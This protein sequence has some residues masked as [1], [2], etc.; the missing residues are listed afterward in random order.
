MTEDTGKKEPKNKTNPET[1]K[2]PQKDELKS[3]I[4]EITRETPEVCSNKRKEMEEKEEIEE[5]EVLEEMEEIEETEEIEGQCHQSS[6]Y[7]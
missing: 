3:I 6:S 2:S 7:I 5:M 4:E 1:I